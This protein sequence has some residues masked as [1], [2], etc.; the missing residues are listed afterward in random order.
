MALKDRLKNV[1]ISAKPRIVEETSFTE[2][3]ADA[4]S[5]K[6]A[7]IPVWYDYDY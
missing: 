4:L 7:T 3:I 6:I 5:Q 2:F 1:N